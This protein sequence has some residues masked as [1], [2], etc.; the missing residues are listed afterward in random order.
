MQAEDPN[1]PMPDKMTWKT[2]LAGY[3]FGALIIYLMFELALPATK[4]S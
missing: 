1:D 3:A 4:I 2:T